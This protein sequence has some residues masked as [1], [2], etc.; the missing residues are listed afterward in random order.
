M[1]LDERSRKAGELDVTAHR[2]RESAQPVRWA[3]E[4]RDQDHAGD[5]Q[6]GAPAP[7]ANKAAPFT[8]LEYLEFTSAAEFSHFRHLA[9]IQQ[10]EI[11]SVD[12]HVLAN[13][14]Q[15]CA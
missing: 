15:H 6:R 8:Y 9:P 2:Q 11:D 13:R 4:P 7:A 14:L 1:G 10:E 5:A 12:W 3:A